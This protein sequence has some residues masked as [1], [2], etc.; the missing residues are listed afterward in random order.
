M[1]ESGRQ[2]QAGRV[3][4][5]ID[6]AGYACASAWS[7]SYC[8]T[9]YVGNVRYDGYIGPGDVVEVDARVIHTGNSSI[10]VLVSVHARALHEADYT[11][12]MHCILVLVAVD[13]Q[14][15]PHPVRR[16]EQTTPDDNIRQRLAL[17]R[18]PVRQRIKEAMLAE[19]YSDQGTT[20]KSTLRFVAGPETANWAGNAHG[21]TV[22]RWISEATATC[23]VLLSPHG[24]RATGTQEASTSTTQSR[25]GIWSK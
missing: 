25:S 12:A 9:A 13:K 19:Y 5:W 22:M 14:G 7:A 6:R 23:A 15:K 18:I 24:A 16:W 4:E 20:P 11:R 10:H 2:V 3:L 1:D 17:E 8:V 21:G